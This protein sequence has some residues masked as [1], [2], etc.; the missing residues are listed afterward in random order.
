MAGTTDATRER[1]LATAGQV[2]AE[3]GFQAATIRQICS[4]ADVNVAAVNYYFGDKERLYIEAVKYAHG[5]VI[6]H[7]GLDPWPPGTPPAE[8]LR[9][10]ITFFVTRLMDPTRPEWHARLMMREMAEPTAACAELVRDN[11]Q[12]LCDVLMRILVDL[13]PAGT[14]RV[15]CF[16]TGF[17]IIG[18]CVMY[19]QNKP[20]I[21]EL[22]GEEDFQRLGGEMVAAHIARFTLAALGHGQPVAS[23]MGVA[24]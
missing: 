9:G 19:C 4:R 5:K 11:I 10:F 2:F 16:Q 15:Q 18:Q 3:K 23:P 6:R 13:L 21:R 22:L 8:Q 7:D 14:S 12:P 1:L 24:T 20:I 17:S